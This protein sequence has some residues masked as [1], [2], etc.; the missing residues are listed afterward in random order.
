MPFAAS[1]PA[2]P[3]SIPLREMA[4]GR[5]GSGQLGLAARAGRVWNRVVRGPQTTGLLQDAAAAARPTHPKHYCGVFGIYGH[6]N[7]AELT[8]CG[9]YAL[10]HRGQESAGIV[11]SD[12][13]QFRAHRGMGLVPQVFNGPL[14]HELVGHMAIGHTRYSTTG[15]SYLRNAQPLTVDCA[16]GQLAVAHNGNLTN[17]LLLREE[18]EAAGSIFQTTV[19]S[20]I[21]LHLLAQPSCNGSANTLV[22]TMRRIQGA[23]S[24]VIMTEKELIGVRDPHGFRPLSLGRVD[25]A[26]VLSSETCAFDLIHG[27]EQDPG[28]MRNIQQAYFSV[29][30]PKAGGLQIDFGK[31]VTSAGAE[32]IETHSNW[33]YSRSL[34]FAWTIPYYHFGLRT[35]MPLH[36]NF[37]A[38][39]QLVNGWN[40]VEDNNSGKTVGLTGALTTSKVSWYHNYYVGPEKPDTN[41]GL[42]HVYDTVL[43]V[44][45]TP[46]V[47]FY[48]NYDYGV[49][50]FA[51]AGSNHWTGV[52]GAARFAVNDWFALAPRLEWFNDAGGFTTGMAQKLKEFTLTGE[53][54]LAGGMFTRLEYR[55]DWS[56]QPYFSRGAETPNR[57]DQSTVLVGMVAHFGQD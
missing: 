24:L 37:T 6:P 5:G 1:Q 2:I 11:S 29:K 31:F 32:V 27:A 34:L 46:K 43:L 39:F 22:Q 14:L 13:R 54:K 18:L 55:R 44:T 12:G 16:R 49:E 30:P 33:N 4:V 26:W 50:K 47:S 17:A 25:D 20:E 48:L 15:E 10:Q 52:A 19:D 36:K 42:R 21:I 40:N 3:P 56:D 38:G 41:K 23:F 53:F 7:A 8:Y 57:K 9:L 51:G 35:S 45:P 28:A